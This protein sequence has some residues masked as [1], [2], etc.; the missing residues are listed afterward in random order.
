MGFQH[1]PA[2]A[3]LDNGSRRPNNCPE[4]AVDDIPVVSA[5]GLDCLVARI[6]GGTFP[7][8]RRDQ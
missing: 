6:V 2:A 1:H 7:P 4:K 3:P 8:P 5:I